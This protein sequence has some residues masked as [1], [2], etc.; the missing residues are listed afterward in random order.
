MFDQ[1]TC[2]ANGLL[3]FRYA[4]G[5]TQSCAMRTPWSSPIMVMVKGGLTRLAVTKLR[6]PL[7]PGHAVGMEA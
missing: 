1:V 3:S 2:S 6:S 5:H 4:I 7:K